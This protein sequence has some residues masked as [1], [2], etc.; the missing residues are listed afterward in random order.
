M[1]FL[2]GIFVLLGLLPG[3]ISLLSHFT[4]ISL[5][6]F[7]FRIETNPS[8]RPIKTQ[9]VN[10]TINAIQQNLPCDPITTYNASSTLIRCIDTTPV[11]I[12]TVVAQSYSHASQLCVFHLYSFYALCFLISF[13]LTI[14]FFDI[15]RKSI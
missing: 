5:F 9:E 12:Y 6:D 15:N 4:F 1:G 3:R 7:D 2:I 13:G 8:R 14:N 10:T 11:Y